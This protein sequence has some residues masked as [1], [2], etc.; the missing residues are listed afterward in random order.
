MLF[1]TKAGLLAPGGFLGV[2]LSYRLVEAPA[3]RLKHRFSAGSAL[4]RAQSRPLLMSPIRLG[5]LL[6]EGPFYRAFNSK[7][8]SGCALHIV[9]MWPW[10][11]M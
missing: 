2:D 4:L 3:L 9:V 1:H 10:L 5:P 8:G 7:P 11:S 6:D